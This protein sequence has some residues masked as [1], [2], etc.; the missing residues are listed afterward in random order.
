MPSIHTEQYGSLRAPLK[1]PRQH[2]SS[3]RRSAVS[4]ETRNN[5]GYTWKRSWLG[6]RL[7]GSV[8]GLSDLSEVSQRSHKYPVLYGIPCR[9]RCW[10]V[11]LPI[12]DLQLPRRR[13]TH[14][15]AHS[16]KTPRLETTQGAHAMWHR[17]PSATLPRPRSPHGDLSVGHAVRHPAWP[18]RRRPRRVAVGEKYRPKPS[19]VQTTI[20][21]KT[22]V[23]T[24]CCLPTRSILPTPS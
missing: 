12:S 20:P 21:P 6:V 2:S 17:S 22:L 15:P 18:P 4:S 16:P 7:W 9:R 14:A 19:A 10:T 1:F 8:R 24:H 3:V 23:R 13:G 11:D 5:S